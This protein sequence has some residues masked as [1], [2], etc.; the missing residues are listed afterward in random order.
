MCSV[1]VE[2]NMR[3][4]SP[5]DASPE[6][7]IP[8]GADVGGEVCGATATVQ[9]SRW[10]VVRSGCVRIPVTPNGMLFTDMIV[11]QYDSDPLE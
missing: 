6:L 11:Y 1:Q 8:V 3:P 4:R 7:I 5:Q 10:R 9:L 2:K